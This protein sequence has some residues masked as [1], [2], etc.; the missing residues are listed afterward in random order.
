MKKRA[1][2]AALT[3]IMCGIMH[4]AGLQGVTNVPPG[5]DSTWISVGEA[6]QMAR[7]S[8]PSLLMSD[9]AT[10][11]ARANLEQERLW[12]NPEVSIT[13]N[14]N[15]PVTHRYF[16][17]GREGETDIQLS[18]RIYVGGQRRERVRRAKAE[19]ARTQ[20]ERDDAARLL[21]RDLCRTMIMLASMQAKRD[22]LEREIASA[23]KVLGAYEQQQAK[24]NVAVAEVTRLRNQH[25]LLMQERLSLD[26]DMRELQS[27]LQLAVGGRGEAHQSACCLCP[28]I[29][30]AACMA[31]LDSTCR[32][33]IVQALEDRPD[34]LAGTQDIVA[35]EH[36]AK[37]QRANALPELSITGEWD[38]N[39]NIGHNFF[40]VGVSLTLPVFNRNQGARRAAQATLDAKRTE[41]EWN[42]CQ[43]QAQVLQAWDRLM[44]CRQM[45]QEAN[46]SVGSANEQMLE[47]ME[48]QYMRHN[49]SL[50]QLLDYYQAYKES[51]YMAIDCRRDV[52][53]AMSELD[54]DIK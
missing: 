34:L 52:L 6:W 10:E 15:N 44:A 40:D 36:E 38:R 7:V 54:L 51:H 31:V 11:T 53:L 48:A 1:C 24:G 21:R 47:Q 4:A 37:W 19:L 23:G 3:T 35:A 18:Q 50:L 17:T 43:A 16:E 26:N 46:R 8:H 49:V 33:G 42:R 41:Q 27:Q 2:T 5:A 14:V 30:Y 32:E 9:K 12:E 39:G 29:D 45:A 28:R 13:H 22:V 20:H 25:M